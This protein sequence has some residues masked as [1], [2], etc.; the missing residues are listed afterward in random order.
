M[1]EL[2]LNFDL[3]FNE[4]ME[5]LD[6]SE[7]NSTSSHE[8]VPS[9][10]GI[11]L[12]FDDISEDDIKNY[13]DPSTQLEDT[14]E[15]G[16]N[17]DLPDDLV[18]IHSDN[19]LSECEVIELENGFDEVNET[20]INSNVEKPMPEY[21]SFPTSNGKQFNVGAV[22]SI[23]KC[24]FFMETPQEDKHK[25]RFIKNC[26]TLVRRSIEYSNYL[27]QI[28]STLD[29]T[30]CSFLHNVDSEKAT[31]EMHH[32]PFSL[33]D[34]TEIVLDKRIS[35]KEPIT[36]MLVADEVLELHFMNLIG[37]V[38]LSVTIHQLTHSGRLFINMTQVFGYVSKFTKL[39]RDY[40]PEENL[41][42]LLKIVEL[43]Q[44]NASMMD[45][46]DLLKLYKPK[47]TEVKNIPFT[48]E[49]LQSFAS[50]VL[51]VDSD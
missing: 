26:E 35:R 16:L 5:D 21:S 8:F 20:I 42:K 45:N 11:D 43:S 37:L 48:T 36:S 30:Q 1:D 25:K 51:K 19:A 24:G 3:S 29:L 47:N 7:I 50:I 17:L 41:A 14:N 34:I 18:I 13:K 10:E 40:I 22:T 32:Y 23:S 2:S 15:F 12:S 31:I 33:Y 38:P 46:E 39:Y 6:S 27:G 9:L 44:S 28:K 4:L 49:E